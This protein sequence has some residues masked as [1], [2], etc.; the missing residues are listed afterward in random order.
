MR[1]VV[2]VIHR[3]G[4]YFRSVE[5]YLRRIS[6]R[7]EERDVYLQEEDG[8]VFLVEG[9]TGSRVRV[10]TSQKFPVLGLV[11]YGMRTDSW[12]ALAYVAPSVLFLRIFHA[13]E[14]L[15]QR[16]DAL[17]GLI[18]SERFSWTGTFDSWLDPDYVRA[19]VDD[20]VWKA[21][22]LGVGDV[23]VSVP[24]RGMYVFGLR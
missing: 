5:G 13:L 11:I 12:P 23:V 14:G 1:E 24:E 2:D 4:T 18:S 10:G 20:A 8:V 6:D 15:A 16:D 7:L 3:G 9:K 21:V 19:K 17:L 22:V